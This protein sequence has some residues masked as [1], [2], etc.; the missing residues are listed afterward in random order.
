[1]SSAA[2][3]TLSALPRTGAVALV[4][5]VTVVDA[6]LTTAP[7]VAATVP[8]TFGTGLVTAAGR[9]GAAGSAGTT[10]SSLRA[11]A[12]WETGEVCGADTAD[13][14]MEATGAVAREP[15]LRE[16]E[17]KEPEPTASLSPVAAPAHAAPQ[18]IHARARKTGSRRARVTAAL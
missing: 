4:T 8:T 17:F 5:E 1:M 11:A 6:P 3:I 2:A 12:T 14:A 15:T 18:M 7:A 9:L 10:G 16:P 13:C